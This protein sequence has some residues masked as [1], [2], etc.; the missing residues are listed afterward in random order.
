MNVEKT[1]KSVDGLV[2]VDFIAGQ[3]VVTDKAE[4]RLV[5]VGSERQL[6]SSKEL[7]ESITAVV[8]VMNFTNLDS[9]VSEVVLDDEGQI[10]RS[11]EEAEDF[12]VIVKELLLAGD[13]TTTKSLLHVLFHIV[14]AWA[15]YLNH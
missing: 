7:G 4:A 14:I 12:A 9:V 5:D 8:G 15:G 10:L 2:W 11:A 6:L 13:L 3:V 1:A